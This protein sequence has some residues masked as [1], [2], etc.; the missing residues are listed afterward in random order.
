MEETRHSIECKHH[1]VFTSDSLLESLNEVS[2]LRKCR[3]SAKASLR[4]SPIII[5]A[6]LTWPITRK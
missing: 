1:H 2:S 6:L 5:H 3:P 4:E